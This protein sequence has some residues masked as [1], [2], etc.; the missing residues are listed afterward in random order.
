LVADAD[1]EFCIFFSLFGSILTKRW[2]TT[3]QL[4]VAGFFLSQRR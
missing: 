1:C 2:S 3:V 4:R